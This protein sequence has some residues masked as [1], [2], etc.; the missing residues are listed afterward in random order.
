MIS[1][2][3][4]RSR[5]IFCQSL[6]ALLVADVAPGFA[7]PASASGSGRTEWAKLDGDAAETWHV[8]LVAKNFA[9]A[10]NR[11]RTDRAAGSH[12]G[13]KCSKLERANARG[14]GESALRKY[15]HGF[16]VVQR[17]F[18][19]FCLFHPSLGIVTVERQMAAADQDRSDDRPLSHFALGDEVGAGRH[20]RHD[21]QNIEV[22]GMIGRKDPRPGSI[23]FAQQVA[24]F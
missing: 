3:A 23:Y 16:A 5:T 4:S 13:L 14:L 7:A 24:A 11:H 6:S 17:I 10:A 8:S 9:R 2:V 18:H 20:M 1:R 21:H 15:H 12:R 22:A 19:H